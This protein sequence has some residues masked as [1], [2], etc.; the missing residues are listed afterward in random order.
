MGAGMLAFVWNIYRSLK[1]PEKT[2]NDPWDGRTLE[3]SVPSPSPEHPFKPVPQVLSSDPY[4]D[5][6]RNREGKLPAAKDARTAPVDVE[7][8]QPVLFAG[9][10]MLFSLAFIYNVVWLQIVTGIGVLLYFVI[11]SVT[12]EHIE[13]AREE[14]KNERS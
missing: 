11:R 13:V 6:K 7:T 10:L 1:Q 9:W 5:A 3:W 4:W 2:S 8:W 14:E 12:D